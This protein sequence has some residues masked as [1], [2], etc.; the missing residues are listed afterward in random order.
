M[1]TSDGTAYHPGLAKLL[2]CA[3]NDDAIDNVQPKLTIKLG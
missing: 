3:N 2:I 1:E